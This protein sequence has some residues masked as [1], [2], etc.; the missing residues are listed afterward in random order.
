M[1]LSQHPPVPGQTC[2]SWLCAGWAPVDVGEYL[3]TTPH[4]QRS[5]TSLRSVLTGAAA[6]QPA[7]HRCL[8]QVRLKGPGCVC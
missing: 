6:G 8:V 4:R 3:A 1:W 2:L 7:K 5:F